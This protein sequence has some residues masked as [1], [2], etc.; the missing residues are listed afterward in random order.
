MTLAV[1]VGLGL[2]VAGVV[3]WRLAAMVLA[4]RTRKRELWAQVGRDRG[5]VLEP[6][7]LVSRDRL[8]GT[9]GGRELV[10]DLNEPDDGP[11]AGKT[12]TRIQCATGLME[13]I[14]VRTMARWTLIRPRDQVLTGDLGFDEA[15]SV[16]GDGPW[17]RGQ[18]TAA[19]RRELRHLVTPD[20]RV[21]DAALTLLVPKVHLGAE[22]LRAEI[23]RAVR[24]V[25]LL[26]PAD[27][28]A[29]ARLLAV[30]RDDPVPEVRLRSLEE[31]ID[32]GGP[33]W[34]D[35][36]EAAAVDSD[37][38]V[39]RRGARARLD[40]RDLVLWDELGE[41]ADSEDPV[42][43]AFVCDL[44]ARHGLLGGREAARLGLTIPDSSLQTAA[45]RAL[46]VVGQREDVAELLPHTR[47]LLADEAVRRAAQRAIA[48]IQ[49]RL[50]GGHGGLAVADQGGGGGLSVAAGGEL[51][52]EEPAEPPRARAPLIS[53]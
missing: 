19:T 13:P 22:R 53:E 51:A 33:G 8:V 40:S 1:A 3:L 29:P 31:L 38:A 14:K 7:G 5:L 52:V 26:D 42:D 21:K 48:S 23:D 36:L 30:L 35:A 16:R 50:G 11:H 41:L 6:G 27:G 25:E 45:A 24:V 9:V 12:C 44:T 37:P 49:E 18:L 2:P 4:S 43:R 46:A 20:L 17:I 47:G 39:R 34:P 28:S 10:V 32:L 15:I